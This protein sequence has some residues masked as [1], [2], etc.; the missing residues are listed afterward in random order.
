MVVNLDQLELTFH[1]VF[2]HY[3]LRMDRMV[4]PATKEIKIKEASYKKEK[5]EWT[6][7]PTTS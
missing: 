6:D 3:F 4:M 7:T 5:M 1:H 2:P